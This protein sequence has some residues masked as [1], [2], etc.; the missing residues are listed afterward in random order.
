MDWTGKGAKSGRRRTKS[1]RDDQKV[2]L[3]KNNQSI[4]YRNAWNV[5]NAGTK[6]KGKAHEEARK[7]REPA[8][9]TLRH[10]IQPSGRGEPS[11][12]LGSANRGFTPANNQRAILLDFAAR[13]FIIRLHGSGA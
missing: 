8:G 10:R 12:V 7:A 6:M 5:V 3:P 4:N 9:T 2:T 11:A 13:S 1:T